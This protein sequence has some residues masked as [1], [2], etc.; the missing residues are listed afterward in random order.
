M[1]E[2]DPDLLRQDANDHW[3]KWSL[4]LESIKLG[5]DE[6]RY[7]LPDFSLIPGSTEVFAAFQ[8]SISTLRTYVETGEEIFEGFARALL[9]SVLEYAA[10][11]GDAQSEID[12]VQRELDAL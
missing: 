2:V 4:E 8:T 3:Q 7:T 5:V 10:A 6:L 12:A 1:A 11:E 9:D